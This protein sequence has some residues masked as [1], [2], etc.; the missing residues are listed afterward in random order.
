MPPMKTDPVV[1]GAEALLEEWRERACEACREWQPTQGN[2][3]KEGRCT[4]CDHNSWAHAWRQ[5]ADQLESGMKLAA[6]DAHGRGP[7]QNH[8]YSYITHPGEPCTVC[9]LEPNHHTHEGTWT[10]VG[11]NGRGPEPPSASAWQPMETMPKDGRQVIVAWPKGDFDVIGRA[12][13]LEIM[14]YGEPSALGWMPLPPSPSSEKDKPHE[15]AAARVDG[16]C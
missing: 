5:A 14:G 15:D 9:R 2:Y 1:R 11:A 6:I 8:V 3:R 16:A 4:R 10:Q 12:E 13:Y 7:E